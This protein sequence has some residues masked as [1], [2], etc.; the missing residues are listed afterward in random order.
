[1]ISNILSDKIEHFILEQLRQQATP[2]IVLKRKEIAEILNCAPSQVTYVINTRFGSNHRFQ[3]ESRRGSGGFIRISVLEHKKERDHGTDHPL[4]QKGNTVDSFWESYFYMLLS[5]GAITMREY[6]ML[7]EL[8]EVV[9]AHC[10]A[11]R[12]KSAVEE[13]ARRIS[14]IIKEGK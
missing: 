14:R 5:S 13:A 4:R 7:K 11:E 8:T 6:L 12:Q 9:M 3:V 2:V 1:M 10:P